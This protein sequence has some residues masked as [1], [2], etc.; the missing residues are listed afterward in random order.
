MEL[1]SIGVYGYT[2]AEFFD[3]I[4][5][6]NI[7]LFCDIR[8]RRAVRGSKYSFVNSTKLQDLLKQLNVSYQHLKFL[9]PSKEIRNLQKEADLNTGISKRSR[10]ELGPEFSENYIIENLNASNINEL[11]FFLNNSGAQKI[12][13]FC[14]ENPH[15]AC[16]RTLVLNALQ[17][18][19]FQVTHI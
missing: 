10:L 11:V 1:F 16:H 8:L 2:E 15:T 9:A 5:Q 4:K 12:A 18:L 17:N 6:Y 3:K 14:V 19:S 7:D 13:F